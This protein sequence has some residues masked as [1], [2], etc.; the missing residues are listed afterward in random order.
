MR[1]TL[2]LCDGT[3]PMLKNWIGL[4]VV[5]L[6]LAA[7]CAST[8]Q[9]S[10]QRDAE[11]KD[12]GTH[13]DSG[14]IYVYRSEHDRLEDDAVLYM[15]G[16]IVGQTLPGTYFRVDTVPGRHVLHGMASMRAGSSWMH[17][18]GPALFR[19]VARHRRRV[20]LPAD[21]GHSRTP[22]HCEVLHAA[23]KLG[24]RAAAADQVVVFGDSRDCFVA[25]LLAM[26]R[27]LSS[28][29][30]AIA[31]PWRSRESPHNLRPRRRPHAVVLH[32]VFQRRIE[33]ADA[34][35]LA[36]EKRMQRQHEQAPVLRAFAMERIERLTIINEYASSSM[37]RSHSALMSSSGS[38]TGSACSSP[39]G[40]FMR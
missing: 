7:G 15:D 1:F 3:L 24:A 28:R 30:D 14:T 36:D 34:K 16:R 23:R 4:F 11:A 21:A 39:S 27:R 13:P 2:R 18:A 6:L 25:A 12:F 22:A 38:D 40:T 37:C 5:A 35:R 8:P 32:D 26:T 17:A 10:K 33:A 9:A 29:G 31:T 20:A 19:R